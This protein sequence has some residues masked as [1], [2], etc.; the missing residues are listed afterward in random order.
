MYLSRKLVQ[1]CGRYLIDVY[2]G[3]EVE[4]KAEGFGV[5]DLAC[6]A[7]GVGHNLKHEQLSTLL[8]TI[9]PEMAAPAERIHQLLLPVAEPVPM[10]NR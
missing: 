2:A 6:D 4:H 3:A 7:A 5:T 1:L 10:R 8:H 9:Q